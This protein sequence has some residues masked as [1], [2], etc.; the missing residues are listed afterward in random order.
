[1][2]TPSMLGPYPVERE[3]GRGGMGVVYLGRD[4]KLMRPVAIRFCP[5]P[6]RTPSRSFRGCDRTKKRKVGG[7]TAFTRRSLHFRQKKVCRRLDY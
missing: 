4:P 7:S 5:M 2:S 3:L 6:S 1:M